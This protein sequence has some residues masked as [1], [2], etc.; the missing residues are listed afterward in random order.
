ML[1]EGHFYLSDIM[2]MHPNSVCNM[3]KHAI[4]SNLC[5]QADV[6]HLLLVSWFRWMEDEELAEE[7]PF[8]F[9]CG[10]GKKRRSH[11]F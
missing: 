2:N 3:Q 6:S 1:L 9:E 7:E 10:S 5:Q 8:K 11:I 4:P